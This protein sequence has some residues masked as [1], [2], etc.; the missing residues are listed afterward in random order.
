MKTIIIIVFIG[1]EIS[2][3]LLLLGIGKIVRTT[4]IVV[5]TANNNNCSAVRN[6]QQQCARLIDEDGQKRENQ[7]LTLCSFKNANTRAHKGD[8]DSKEGKSGNT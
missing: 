7:W 8:T 6:S 1:G 2:H 5:L 3:Q 4:I